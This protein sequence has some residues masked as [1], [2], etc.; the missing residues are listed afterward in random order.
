[1]TTFA[2]RR[3]SADNEGPS[4]RN[5]H[6]A[7]HAPPPHG[8]HDAGP[9]RMAC[10]ATGEMGR[11]YG[12]G[13]AD[14]LADGSVETAGADSAGSVGLSTAGALGLGLDPD[15]VH[16]RAAAA[17]TSMISKRFMRHLLREWHRLG[18]MRVA[19]VGVPGTTVP[20]AGGQARRTRF[21]RGCTCRTEPSQAGDPTGAMRME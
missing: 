10:P 21:E 17:R 8:Q 20:S 18:P 3:M 9:P 12:A 5:N 15:G 6:L 11:R 1:M 7:P 4:R 19:S 14:S 2:S 16:A 13:D